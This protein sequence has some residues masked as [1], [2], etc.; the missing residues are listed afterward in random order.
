MLCAAKKCILIHSNKFFFI[1]FF[2]YSLTKNWAGLR[3]FHLCSMQLYLFIQM[4][5]IMCSI[6]SCFNR[7]SYLFHLLL[8]L[9]LY[10]YDWAIILKTAPQWKHATLVCA[11]ECTLALNWLAN[12]W[13]CCGKHWARLSFFLLEPL[14][15]QCCNLIENNDEPVCFHA[16]VISVW[17]QHHTQLYL[18]LFYS[19]LSV[20][21]HF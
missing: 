16:A 5:R 4:P 9:F 13:S 15:C 8:I 18:A 6:L 2:S 14:L 17:T 10:D 11:C 12:A 20:E 21:E 3:L 7:W 1:H 19:V